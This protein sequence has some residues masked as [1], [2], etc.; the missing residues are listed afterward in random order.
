MNK[1]YF[2]STLMNKVTILN[3]NYISKFIKKNLIIKKKSYFLELKN[4]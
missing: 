3:V 4:E 2:N 1:I